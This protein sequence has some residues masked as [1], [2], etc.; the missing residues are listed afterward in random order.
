MPANGYA[1]RLA[2]LAAVA[3]ELTRATRIPTAIVSY[4]IV[5]EP[6]SAVR[7]LDRFAVFE[8]VNRVRAPAGLKRKKN[9]APDVRESRSDR[10]RWETPHVAFVTRRTSPAGCET[11]I[12]K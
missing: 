11:K 3:G 2:L 1:Y 6:S 7:E 12:P 8:Y 5:R 9:P 4:R 10:R